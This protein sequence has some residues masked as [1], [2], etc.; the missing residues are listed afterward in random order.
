MSPIGA[1]GGIERFR[2]A[3][4]G[5]QVGLWDW[6]IAEST[7]VF[8]ARWK[9]MLGYG[10]DEF[11]DEFDRWAEALHPD[12]REPTLAKVM[13]TVQGDGSLFENEFRM[14]HRDGTWR[15]VLARAVV[16]RDANGV[17]TRMAGS[18]SDITRLKETE[19]ELRHQREFV[20]QVI[21]T[22]PNLVFV[23]DAYGRFLLV[24]QAVADIFG[25]PAAEIEQQA[26]EEVHP[27]QEEVDGYAQV[28][29][30]VIA[31]RQAIEV[32]EP[33]TKFDGETLWY[34]TV[35]APLVRPDGTV[36]VLAV[37]TDITARKRAQDELERS[38]GLQ[39]SLNQML[40]L[41]L[42]ALT[43]RE[44]LE[45][46]LELVVDIPRPHALRA[47]GIRVANPVTGE[48]EMTAAIALD[49]IPDGE[50]YVV[51]IDQEGEVEGELLLHVPG[52]VATAY[53]L[54]CF[55]LIGNTLAGMIR[56]K[57]AEDRLRRA[58]DESDAANRAKSEFLATMSHE[59]RTPLN[60]VIGMLTLLQDRP[61][62]QESRQFADTARSSAESLLAIIN[63]VLDVSR[64]EAGKLSFETVRFPLRQLVEDVTEAL[65]AEAD[66][67]GL[68]LITSFDPD[69]PHEVYSDPGRL[70][71][72]LTNLVANALKFTNWG[73]VSVEI[74]VDDVEP[75]PM[76]SLARVRLEV[77]DTGIG[78]SPE[79]LDD[80][81]E[82]FTQV[83]TSSTRRYQGTGLGLSITKRIVEHLGGEI[84][85]ASTPGQGSTFTV[86][87]PLPV[88]S[89]TDPEWLV[90][91]S[92]AG[93]RVLVA[94]GHPAER[95]NLVREL[96]SRGL[97]A[98]GVES[99][100]AAL[101]ELHRA[102]A[103]ATPV[104]MVFVDAQLADARGEELV[105]NIAG[106]P[107]LHVTRMI[108]M[109]RPTGVQALPE[110]LQD[111]VG[112]VLTK[113]V[114][115][116]S[117]LEV[118]QQVASTDAAATE[119]P[120][121]PVRAGQGLRVL[122]VEDNAVNRLVAVKMLEALGHTVDVALDGREAV[123]RTAERRYDA[124]FMDCM[125]PEMD[126]YQATELIR[127][128]EAPTG[129]RVPIIALTANAMAGTPE[130]C[131]AAGMD[132]YISKP[133]RPEYLREAM[134][135]HCAAM[136]SPVA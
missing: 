43:I 61:L 31:T 34:Q 67:K 115:A 30:Q 13:G 126:G 19:T 133:V 134:T 118:L 55:D 33:F 130:R 49:T 73:H 62:P 38:Y 132:G 59:I 8:S 46:A 25:R 14:R 74:I 94:A 92:L 87:L 95:R 90:Q 48:L 88:A 32:E 27:H 18:H 80:I 128:R 20:R 123:A 1:P 10:P 39:M 40:R 26:N 53:D 47:G 11:P 9:A 68:S 60:A 22:D 85:V 81:F 36:H 65:A 122:V 75:T 79:K 56:A 58:R 5:S 29:L 86:T 35:K 69:L 84:A 96:T 102:A 91:P 121:T 37:S 127:A 104:A 114:R 119:Y 97:D 44:M 125:M 107:S 2:L 3:I 12:D 100:G 93:A 57:G 116:S 131:A 7:V 83:D 101:A 124:V 52:G 23:K 42:Q 4:Q 50:R 16:E 64:I 28:D 99:G 136:E 98:T 72:V 105:A 113:P 117:L 54:R 109:A 76:G 24:N 15:W 63:D 110:R 77:R 108:F 120:G 89:T 82:K 17:A 51:A 112:A 106:T 66:D 111:A 71:Q 6:N 41:S 135:R 103:A 70:R 21:D 45:S 78:I 129:D